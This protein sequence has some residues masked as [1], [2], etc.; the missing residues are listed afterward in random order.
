[1]LAMMLPG[2][3]SEAGRARKQ[4][5]NGHYVHVKVRLCPCGHEFSEG[6]KE[7][8]DKQ[9]KKQ[10]YY[11]EP[12]RGRRKCAA[13]GKYAGVRAANCPNCNAVMGEHEEKE[14]CEVNVYN[15]GGKGRKACPGCNKFV[16][17][18]T[19]DCSCGYSFDHLTLEGEEEYKEDEVAALDMREIVSQAGEEIPIKVRLG[20]PTH[21]TTFTPSGECP[22]K[23][24]STDEASVLAWIK[25][26]HARFVAKGE[27]LAPS[28]Y[29]YYARYSFGYTANDYEQIKRVVKQYFSGFGC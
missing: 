12:G 18:R 15:E 29:T 22:V 25:E 19:K 21:R 4:C 6:A 1:M 10:S 17:C 11:D 14:R 8:A 3:Y 20:Y 28:G 26:V 13:C 23:L 2:T 5:P 16:G 27:V 9:A 7:A 24:T